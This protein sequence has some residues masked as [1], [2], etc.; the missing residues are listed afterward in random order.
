MEVCREKEQHKV[1]KIE[2]NGDTEKKR[3]TEIPYKGEGERDSN[4]PTKALG[5]AYS[6]AFP[7]FDIPTSFL[8]CP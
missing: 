6:E 1:K 4:D 7:I 8:S 2:R 5:R 3:R